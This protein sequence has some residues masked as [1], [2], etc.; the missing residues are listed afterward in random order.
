VDVNFVDGVE[1]DIE[2][3]K[4]WR[5]GEYADA[6]MIL[7]GGKYICGSEVEKMSKSKFNTIDPD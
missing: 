6:E 1:L 2:A 5:N 7:D 4:L 3:F